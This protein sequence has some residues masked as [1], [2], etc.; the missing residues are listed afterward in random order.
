VIVSACVSVQFAVQLN[1]DQAVTMSATWPNSID[2][3]SPTV[4]ANKSAI[5]RSA[6]STPV[7]LTKSQSASHNNK[8]AINDDDD[9][10]DDVSTTS[11]TN[12]SRNA[13]RGESD[14]DELSSSSWEEEDAGTRM[15]DMQRRDS[16]ND[17]ESRVDADVVL[18][19]EASD[20]NTVLERKNVS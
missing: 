10:N 3:H 12:V 11:A 2:E 14:I 16:H 9:D 6:S 19:D 4:V 20:D 8:T 15:R 17:A 13:R 18:L 1:V 7:S 5:N